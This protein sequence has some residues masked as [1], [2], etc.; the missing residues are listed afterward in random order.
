MT[1]QSRATAAALA[2]P[3]AA[4]AGAMRLRNA[5]YNRPGAYGL[6]QVY[7]DPCDPADEYFQTPWYEVSVKVTTNRLEQ[8]AGTE[9]RQITLKAIVLQP[10]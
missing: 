8:V 2:I 4:Y 10:F 1:P 6:Q 5:W 3:E 9:P 7:A